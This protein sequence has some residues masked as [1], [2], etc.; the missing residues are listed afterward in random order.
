MIK[1]HSKRRILDNIRPLQSRMHV[2]VLK[3]GTGDFI[4]AVLVYS[5]F[6]SLRNYNPIIISVKNAKSRGNQR[7]FS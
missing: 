1:Q 4:L 6:V 5:V 7:F 3:V 2:S